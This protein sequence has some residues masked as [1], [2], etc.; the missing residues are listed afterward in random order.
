MKTKENSYVVYSQILAIYIYSPD[1]CH[2]C[3]CWLHHKIGQKEQTLAMKFGKKNEFTVHSKKQHLVNI[4]QNVV[5]D[6]M[7]TTTHC[8]GSFSPRQAEPINPFLFGPEWTNQ[9]D[10]VRPTSAPSLDGQH[11]TQLHRWISTELIFCLA[12]LTHSVRSGTPIPY[13]HW[14]GN[15]RLLGK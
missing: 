5:W 15:S 2:F 13:V 3:C 11:D 1:G 4:Y 10:G 12:L 7:T 9:H 8:S 14:K 6:Q